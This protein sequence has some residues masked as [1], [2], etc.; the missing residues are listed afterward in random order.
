[1]RTLLAAVVLFG[2]IGQVDGA[3]TTVYTD[4]NAFDAAFPVANFQGWDGYS[5]G[6][7]IGNGETLDGITYSSSSG[8]SLVTG[9]WLYSSSPNT[10]G[11]TVLSYFDS[12][13]S[14]TFTF[15]DPIRAFGIDINTFATDSGYT[16][17]TSNGE[18]VTSVYNPFPG[19]GTGEFIGFLSDTPFTSVEIAATSDAIA[20]RGDYSYT[21]D[22]MR[23][24]SAAAVPEPYSVIIWSALGTA[25]IG[26]GWWQKRKAA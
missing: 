6:R 20:S 8:G 17:R 23:Y 2:V 25:A 13:D 5:A 24:V 21:L 9:A 3:I 1:M 12:K 7:V 19:G 18:V 14:V 4:R 16:A 10:L 15:S 22:S 26:F 11:Q